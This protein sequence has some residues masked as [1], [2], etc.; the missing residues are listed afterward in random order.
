MAFAQVVNR[1]FLAFR[2]HV[3][4]DLTLYIFVPTMILSIS[5]TTPRRGAH[6]GGRVHG[7]G[8]AGRPRAAASTPW[9]WTP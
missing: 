5:L 4:G 2:G 6:L 8:F 9:R 7:S 1:Y 3:I